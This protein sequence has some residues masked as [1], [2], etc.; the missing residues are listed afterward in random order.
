LLLLLLLLLLF[1]EISWAHY[2][3]NDSVCVNLFPVT[4]SKFRI[5]VTFVIVGL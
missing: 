1:L 3:R 4:A 2:L 5:D